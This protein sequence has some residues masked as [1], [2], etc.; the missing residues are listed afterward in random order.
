MKTLNCKTRHFPGMKRLT[1]Y[2]CAI[3]VLFF[4]NAV[5]LKAQY[6]VSE[7]PT[8]FDEPVITREIEPEPETEITIWSILYQN[9][10]YKLVSNVLK[11]RSDSE[12]SMIQN[13][14]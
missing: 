8:T 3:V 9:R 13:T 12:E 11:T 14:R 7:N 6:S 2:I 1:M 10:L 5:S 4:I